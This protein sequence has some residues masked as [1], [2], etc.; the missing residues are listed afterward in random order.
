MSKPYAPPRPCGNLEGLAL[1][2]FTRQRSEA[3]DL[4]PILESWALSSIPDEWK[5]GARDT[6]I[7]EAE[8]MIGREFPPP[9]RGV[10]QVSDGLSILEGNLNFHPLRPSEKRLG[11]TNASDKL[12]EWKWPIP[13]ELVVFGD[14]GGDELFGVWLPE[15]PVRRTSCPVI[16]VGEIFDYRAREIGRAHV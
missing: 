2:D 15:G 5:P 3:P 4:V 10:Y 16:E 12:R 7:A 14:N 6:E 1:P 9:L 8:R 13:E 11:L